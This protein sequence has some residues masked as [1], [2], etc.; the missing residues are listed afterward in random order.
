MKKLLYCLTLTVLF[1]SCSSDGTDTPT[2]EP[3]GTDETAPEIS[4]SVPELIE[5]QTDIDVSI[6]DEADITVKIFV[7]SE[8]VFSGEAKDFVYTLDPFEFTTGNKTLEVRATDTSGNEG[9]VSASFELKKLLVRIPSPLKDFFP[10]TTDAYLAINDSSGALVMYRKVET[11]DDGVFYADDTFE[12]QNFTLTRYRIGKASVSFQDLDSFGDI[13]PGTT[14]LSETQ[15]ADVFNTDSP[16]LPRDESLEITINTNVFADGGSYSHAL[17]TNVSPVNGYTLQYATSVTP[18]FLTT[19]TPSTGADPLSYAYLFIT[20]LNKLV[21]E[22]DD[23][24]SPST[25]ATIGIP[26]GESYSL[27]MYGYSDEAAY[28]AYEYS[29]VYRSSQSLAGINITIPVLPEFDVYQR[30]LSLELGNGKRLELRQKGIESNFSIPNLDISRMGE[31]LTLDGD[32]DYIMQNLFIVDGSGATRN[33]FVWDFYN[34]PSGTINIPYFG[35][36][37]F[38]Q[39]VEMELSVKSIETDPELVD[40]LFFSS[41]VYKFESDINYLD[42]IFTPGFF[43]NEAGDMSSLRLDLE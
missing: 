20:D 37:V 38:P 18:N 39:E 26:Q 25:F 8:E 13:E 41:T 29:E 28:Q 7:D 43:K 4:I 16:L 23:F 40:P 36:F 32:I 31:S 24:A 22:E 33:S 10:A 30:R 27:N 5:V 21:Y 12:R 2:P 35:N 11:N 19:L 17:F 6:T 15:E 9:N 1:L 3:G 14:V 42:V 34:K